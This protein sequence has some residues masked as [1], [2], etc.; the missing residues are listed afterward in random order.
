M[1]VPSNLLA[2][3]RGT[4]G[5]GP[6]NIHHSR[7][8]RFSRRA[9]LSWSVHDDGGFSGSASDVLRDKVG[10]TEK[11]PVATCRAGRSP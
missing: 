6:L 4:T 7:H 3:T 10:L 8:G 5:V 1:L 11:L 9:K 2:A